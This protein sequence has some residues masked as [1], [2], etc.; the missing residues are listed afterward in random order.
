MSTFAGVLKTEIIRLA[1][2]ESKSAMVPVIRDNR[3]LKT[4]VSELKRRLAIV[5]SICRKAKL[6]VEARR[7]ES[8]QVD[9]TEVEST[10]LTGKAVN[11]LRRK[12][13]LSQG[14]F[15][16]LAKV[17]SMT[18]FQWEH[19]NGVLTLR[20]GAKS[21]LLELK[22]LTRKEALARLAEMGTVPS[23]RGRPKK[24]GDSAVVTELEVPSK[25]RKRVRKTVK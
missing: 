7:A 22:K 12:F 6:V 2:K 4:T 15:A 19:R 9:A 1:R 23:R 11:R 13:R 10:R 17:S 3:L 25:A 20:G 8:I 18:I 14:D 24:Q 5:E 16:K 21:R